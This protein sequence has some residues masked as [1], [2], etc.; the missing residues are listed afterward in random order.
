[1]VIE[2]NSEGFEELLRVLKEYT[3]ENLYIGFEISHG[4]LVDFLRFHKFKLYHINPLNA[5]RFK[6][7]ECTSGNKLENTAQIDTS[8]PLLRGL[9]F[10]LCG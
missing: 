3:K 8:L 5:K 2:N 7:S 10:G 1:M 9:A 4:P 6:E